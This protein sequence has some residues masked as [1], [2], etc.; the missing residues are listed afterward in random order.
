MFTLG[1]G[2]WCL[3]PLWTIFQ[4]YCGSQFLLTEETGVPR[5]NVLHVLVANHWHT[6]SYVA[7][8]TPRHERDSNSQLLGTIGALYAF[9][10]SFSD[11]HL[12]IKKVLSIWSVNPNVP[13][14]VYFYI[15]NLSNRNGSDSEANCAYR[16]IW[17]IPGGPPR[18]AAY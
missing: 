6:L 4:L 1:L 18:Q 3:A 13:L 11:I 5:E 12:T 9:N 14:F 10:S 2:L 7:L 15:A 8:S 16:C 17:P